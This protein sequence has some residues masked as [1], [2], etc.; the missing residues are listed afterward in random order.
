M[1]GARWLRPL[2]LALLAIPR[3]AD[4]G[5]PGLPDLTVSA[6]N[7]ELELDTNVPPGDV[8][9]G[10]ASATNGVDLLRFDATTHNVGPADLSIGDPMCPSCSQ[11]PG[12]TCAN[13]DFHCSP[14][15]GHGHAHFT[16]Y[17]RYELFHPDDLVN[18][19]RVGG[20][21]GFC[22][23][24]TS[25]EAGVTPFF[26]CSFQGLT[27]GCEDLYSRF[28]GCQYIEVTG[29][30]DGDY[31]V[32]VTADPEGKIGEIDDTNNV[33][34][35]SVAVAG[36]QE[37]DQALPGTALELKRKRGAIRLHLLAESDAG[38]ELPPESLAPSVGGALLGFEDSGRG[39]APA[40][41]ELPAA[42]WRGLGNPP[43]A[44][45]YRYRG[46]EGDA[47]R[48]AKLTASRLSVVC[49]G[50]LE[51]PAVGELTLIFTTSETKRYC[52]RFGGTEKRNDA[53]KLRRVKAAPF[54]CPAS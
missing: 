28:L 24:D 33:S 54:A 31:V 46:G 8:A 37:L 1:R 30:P 15:N 49:S 47:C 14:A 48:R 20:K 44:K 19:L 34:E 41:F 43:G 7:F 42:G 16:N 40:A 38:F 6:G 29:L 53:E 51:L 52:A 11:F 10:C 21:F 2:L 9:E 39:A 50:A 23:E 4:A 27:A 13:P 35:Y 5:D 32:R 26:D 25:C 18:R 36:A 22:L 3:A 12:A 17:A 45:G